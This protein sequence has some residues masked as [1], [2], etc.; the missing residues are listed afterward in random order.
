[1]QPSR[2]LVYFERPTVF[3]FFGFFFLA[4][5]HVVAMGP[6]RRDSSKPALA[7]PFLVAC[8]P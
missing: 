6:C 7:L 4:W 3:L 5:G 1:M 2:T 8:M